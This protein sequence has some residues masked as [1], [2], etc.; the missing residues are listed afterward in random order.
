MAHVPAALR[1]HGTA[2]SSGYFDLSFAPAST[3]C[4]RKDY[5]DP[6]PIDRLLKDIDGEFTRCD[7][8][9]LSYWDPR[10]GDPSD[11]SH[12]FVW[13]RFGPLIS[14]NG[15]RPRQLH[16]GES[17]FGRDLRW[18]VREWAQLNVVKPFESIS[19]AARRCPHYQELI[20]YRR[21]VLHL[22]ST[23]IVG[24]CPCRLC[25]IARRS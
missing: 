13:P 19:D 21:A 24:G 8:L 3:R 25:N 12:S 2:R 20:H 11:H 22:Q 17:M 18:R 7:A 9:P 5:A 10:W 14:K 6:I 1:L 4:S 23:F 16:H 15:G